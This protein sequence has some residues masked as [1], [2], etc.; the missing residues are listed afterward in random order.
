MSRC[1]CIS[2]YL[3]HNIYMYVYVRH[4][5]FKLHARFI[6]YDFYSI[7]LFINKLKA[8]DIQL[9]SIAETAVAA[10]ADIQLLYK[11]TCLIMYEP[12]LEMV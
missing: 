2:T 1:L 10:S 6:H 12:F 4:L 11:F 8:F 5:I 7:R 9:V 3:A